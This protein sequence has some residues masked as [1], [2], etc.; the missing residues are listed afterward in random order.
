MYKD[1]AWCHWVQAD[2]ALTAVHARSIRVAVPLLVRMLLQQP[3]MRARVEV[4]QTLL[5]ASIALDPDL[6]AAENDFLATFEVNAELYDI[7][8]VY[9]VRAR[10][11]ART[12]QPDVIEKGARRGLD[13]FYVPLARS[14]PE[15]AMPSR[16]D[17]ALEAHGQG[18]RIRSRSVTLA[19]PTNPYYRIRT[20][21][22]PRN[23][24]EMQTRS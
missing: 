21:Q 15:L 12:R 20:L 4:V 13:V 7:A 11:D 1:S 24:R 17:F 16:D 6:H 10:L 3:L 9:R 23:S 22:R 2:T 14:T 18:I 5:P 8:V 19:V